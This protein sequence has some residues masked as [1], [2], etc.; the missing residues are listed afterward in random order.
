MLVKGFFALDITDIDN[1]KHLFAFKNDASAKAF[2]ID[3]NENENLYGYG[4]GTI[5][6]GY[7]YSKLGE[8][9]STPRIIKIKVSGTEKWVAVFADIMLQ[10]ILI[11]AQLY[12]L[13][14]LKM[15]E[16]F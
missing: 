14:I 15:E 9:W 7:D 5:A 16:N 2:I 8:T 4:S 12:L 10:Q 3:I 1:P 6:S 13:L 11:M